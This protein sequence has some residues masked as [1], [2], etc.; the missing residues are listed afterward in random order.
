[1]VDEYNSA[2]MDWEVIE[3]AAEK[4]ESE[5][6]RKE[7]NMS[8]AMLLQVALNSLRMMKECAAKRTTIEYIHSLILEQKENK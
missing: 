5:N 8:N 4:S 7:A 6:I 1:M 3:S 2:I